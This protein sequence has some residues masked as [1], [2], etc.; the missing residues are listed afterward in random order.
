M[1]ISMHQASAPRFANALRNLSGILDKTQAWA[2]A[3]KIDPAVPGGLRLIADMFP[4]SRQVQTACDTAKLAAFLMY[5]HG[6][7]IDRVVP[8]H[9]WR[10]IGVSPEHKDCPHFLLDNGREGAT[11]RW[12][13]SRVQQQY[14]RIV[15]GP[16]PRI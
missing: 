2:E 11:W 9:H 15:P 3:K 1:K 4:L 6:I 8:H 12:F 7:G 10:R 16:V 13:L 5:E 14:S